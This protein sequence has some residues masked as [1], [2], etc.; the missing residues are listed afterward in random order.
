MGIT[1]A[2]SG[3]ADFSGITNQEQ[4]NISEVIHQAFIAVDEQGTE[5]AAATA[6]GMA[7]AAMPVTPPPVFN[8]NHPFIFMIEDIQSGNILFVGQVVKP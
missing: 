1:A 3:S 8:A 2:F 4:L 6:I 5:A 7:G